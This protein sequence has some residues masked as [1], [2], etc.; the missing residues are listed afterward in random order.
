MLLKPKMHTKHVL[1]LIIGLVLGSLQAKRI[2]LTR[3]PSSADIRPMSEIA[4]SMGRIALE[5]PRFGSISIEVRDVM[6]WIENYFGF[7]KL[8]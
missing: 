3:N 2:Y 4:S 5:I 6:N 8:V 7:R 1:L